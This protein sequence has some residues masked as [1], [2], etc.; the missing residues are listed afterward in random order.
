MDLEERSAAVK[1]NRLVHKVIA[2]SPIRLNAGFMRE[3][4]I[5]LVVHGDDFDEKKTDF[6][7]APRLKKANCSGSL[8]KRHFDNRIDLSS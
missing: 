4:E 1:A 5:Q 2:N 3:H 7:T 8:H 6:T